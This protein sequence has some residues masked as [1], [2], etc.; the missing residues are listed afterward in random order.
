MVGEDGS[1]LNWPR[2]QQGKQSL[3][4]LREDRCILV[5][6]RANEFCLAAARL[7]SHLPGE[8]LEA[9]L[10]SVQ[11]FVVS[12]R[13]LVLILKAFIA[14]HAATIGWQRRVRYGVF[15][16]MQASLRWSGAH[17]NAT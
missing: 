10:N 7:I 8:S 14:F 12:V 6:R 4:G 1:T 3:F 2:S 5:A 11:A 13:S 17:V 15:T 16:L 9:R